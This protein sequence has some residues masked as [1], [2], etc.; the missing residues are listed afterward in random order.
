MGRG[1]YREKAGR[2]SGWNHSSTQTIRVP[3]AF[4]AQLLEYAKRLD[5]G[6]RLE[7]VQ[8]P[9]DA[10]KPPLSTDSNQIDIF[11]YLSASL[12]FDT[13]SKETDES[14]APS[15]TLESVSKSKNPP[16]KPD[17]GRWLSS[18]QAH[19]IA[20]ERG[21]ERTLHGFTTRAR[22]EPEECLQIYALRRLPPLVKGNT[23]VPAFED[24]RHIEN[25]P[26]SNIENESRDR[27]I[28]D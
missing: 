12:D 9:D 25:G 21:C 26:G 27:G 22:R 13:D 3:K 24:V 15:S 14:E 28:P 8:A 2:K 17:G 16:N 10:K 1:G 23:S 6:E 4:A 19:R 18:K 5:A 20:V 7:I 11:S